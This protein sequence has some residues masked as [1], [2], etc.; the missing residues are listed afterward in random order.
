MTAPTHSRITTLLSESA[1]DPS[2]VPELQSYVKLQIQSL[3]SNNNDSPY[4]FDG[5]RTLIKLYQFF[6]HLS[7][8]NSISLILFLSLLEYPNTDF[9]ALCCLVPDKIQTRHDSVVM[10]LVNSSE[11]LEGC[12]FAEFWKVYFELGA[13]S[14]SDEGGSDGDVVKVTKSVLAD[15]VSCPSVVDK[16]RCA[17]WKVL[18]VT[19][20]A[21]PLDMIL[22]SLYLKDKGDLEALA[23]REEEVGKQLERVSEEMVYFAATEEN[24]KKSRVFKEGVKFDVIAGLTTTTM[25]MRQ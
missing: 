24:T 22:K 8:E 11:L 12:E 5:N 18:I 23:R 17:I 16:L 2:I 13:V 21:A 3:T 20:R 1:Y 14:S 15:I 19:Y 9:S 6:P 25:G 7:D 4:H 10:A